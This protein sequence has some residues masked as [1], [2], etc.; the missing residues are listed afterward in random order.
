[1]GPQHPNP[2]V[3]QKLHTGDVL[4]LTTLLHLLDKIIL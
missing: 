3:H 2:L 4:I 1:M